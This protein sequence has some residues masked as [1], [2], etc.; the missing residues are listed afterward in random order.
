M[1]KE[2]SCTATYI[3][4][5]T[6]VIHKLIIDPDQKSDAYRS[7]KLFEVYKKKIIS[8][9]RINTLHNL[10]YYL[11]IQCLIK[12]VHTVYRDTSQ[13]TARRPTKYIAF[14]WCLEGHTRQVVLL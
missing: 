8:F 11:Y 9:R 13:F 2:K 7:F 12:N 1:S 4:Y 10:Y 14:V 3:H 5:M 6:I